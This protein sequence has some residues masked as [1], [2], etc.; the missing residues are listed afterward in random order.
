MSQ[1]TILI[2]DDE[3]T[4]R[5][6]LAQVLK[7]DEGFDVIACPDGTEALRALKANT[8]DA[9]VT[10]LRMPGVTGMDLIDRARKLAP[11]AVIVVITA[12]GEVETAVEAM[13]K[14]AQDYLCKPL[15]FDELVF[16]LKRLLAHEDLARRDKVLREQIR[17]THEVSGIIGRSPA[18][19][20]IVDT[21]KRIAHT[22]SN[23]LICGESGTGKEVLA[24][25]LH[26]AGITKEEPF[27]A[28][29]C[30]GL[31]ETLVESELFGYR[32]GA[33]T[34]AE[35]DRMGYFEAAN[36]GTLF[37]DEI[38]NLPLTS[39]AVLLRA[40]EERTI[41]RVG[42]TRPRPVNIRII[43]ATNRDLERA[44]EAGEFREDLYYRLNV[45]RLTVPPLRERT[46][47]IPVLI[48]HFVHKYNEELKC[49]CPGFD[50][51][52]IEAMV[53]HRWRGNV[54]ELENVIER[55]LI[56]AGN[57]RVGVADLSLALNGNLPT[58]NYSVSLRAAMR[59]FERQ[60]IAKVL[61]SYGNSKAATADAL[62]IGLSSLYRK[63]EELGIT[64]VQAERSPSV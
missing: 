22:I 57:R 32:K 41:I 16:K 3:D 58:P 34:G 20:A 28:V 60:H 2:A 52:A 1:H 59:E 9:V 15:V 40:I 51:D 30:G 54:R 29:N 49:S 4:L 13:K 26:Y 36:D 38:G 33:F 14:G 21:I 35:A 39:Q 44:I 19:V 42:D 37:F 46:E 17:R 43:A 5:K 11:D 56:F 23:V 63:M 6:N 61:S 8:I 55:A 12:F 48:K 31:T 62:G 27:V 64:T 18:I 24:R 10:D 7:E 47:D 53:G 25:G 45:I 50:D